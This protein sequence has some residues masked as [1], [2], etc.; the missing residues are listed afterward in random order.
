[1]G[2]TTDII[3][4]V[5]VT[6]KLNDT[7]VG[8]LTAFAGTRRWF[9]PAGR[10]VVLDNPAVD[11]AYDDVENYNRPWLGEPSLWC[12][13]VPC[14]EGCCLSFDGREKFYAPSSGCDT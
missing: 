13:W 8:Y 5:E 9:R 12:Q 14:W 1:M 6:P 11:E 3:G 2:Y 10:Y 7:E 4:T